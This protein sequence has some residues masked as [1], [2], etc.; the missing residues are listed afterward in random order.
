MHGVMLPHC[1]DAIV[2]IC[3]RENDAYLIHELF[4]KSNPKTMTVSLNNES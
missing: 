2:N 1:Y 3:F 4:V